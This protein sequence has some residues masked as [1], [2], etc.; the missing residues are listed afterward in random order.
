MNVLLFSILIVFSQILMNLFLFSILIVF[1]NFLLLGVSQRF[2]E[3]STLS[4]FF[5]FSKSML[6]CFYN[7]FR[8]HYPP[9]PFPFVTP[10]LF[11]FGRDKYT[12]DIPFKILLFL[13]V[14]AIIY[15]IS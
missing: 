12:P 4:M 15:I 8:S 13:F 6:L 14:F 9:L 10:L 2:L 7:L 3:L 11:A 5:N 1:R